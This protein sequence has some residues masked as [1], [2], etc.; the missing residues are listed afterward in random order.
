MNML[1][2]V[3]CTS[4]EIPSNI[5]EFESLLTSNSIPNQIKNFL[6]FQKIVK[7]R[8][9][10]STKIKYFPWNNDALTGLW[11]AEDKITNLTVKFREEFYIYLKGTGNFKYYQMRPLKIPFLDS[12]G[13]KQIYKPLALLNY[14]DDSGFP[15]NVPPLLM[16]I[17]SK[18]DIDR[19]KSFLH[20]AFRAANRFALS[21]KLQF[22]IFHDDYF[23]S[24]FF[25][26]LSF[27]YSYLNKFPKE[28][29]WKIIEGTIKNHGQIKLSNLYNLYLQ[30][31]EKQL[32]ELIYDT[33]V[34]V[35]L[36]V[37]K[38]V[39]NKRFHKD[40]LIWM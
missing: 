4:I 5:N 35:A 27:I 6:G 7:K 40:T 30:E 3:N 13:N 12:L 20:P 28:K 17:W 36:R 38:V 24:D 34:M 8:K 22:K 19:H 18:K 15:R 2:N 23:L 10:Y 39:W 26:N 21:R 9:Y 31:T 14:R 1:E 33:W 32:E 29:N 25:F 16:D 37:V 11:L